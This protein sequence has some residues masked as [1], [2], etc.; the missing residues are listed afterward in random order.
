ME[1]PHPL[2]AL[3]QLQLGSDS[4]AVLHLPYV[5]EALTP[6][7][8]LPSPHTEKWTARVNSLL[9]SKD[10]G[11]RWSGLCLALQTAAFSRPLMMECAQNWI[12]IALPMLSKNEPPPTMKA[13]IRLLR[14]VSPVRSMFQN[15]NGSCEELELKLL[16]I[17][18]LAHLIPL[19]P[20]L[21][22]ALQN[23]LNTLALR[24]LNGSA[25]KPTPGPLLEVASR[26]YS[27][28]PTTG[29][30]VGASNI[31]RKSIDDTLVFAWTALTSIRTTY[32]STGC[33]STSVT[34]PGSLGVDPMVSIPLNTDRLRA[35][36]H[37][38]CDL[39]RTTTSRPISVPVGSLV[40]LF[41]ALLRCTP[42]EKVDGHIDSSVRALEKSVIP[43]IWELACGVLNALAESAQ[44]HL[45][46]HLPQL[47]SHV[48]YH[49]EQNLTPSQRLPFLKVT[50]SLFA[51]CH[52]MHD[53]VLSSRLLRAILPSLT[54]VL[55]TKSEVQSNTEQSTKGKSKGKKRA[56]G[57]E[58]DEVFKVTREIICS[59]VDDGAV[60]LA[61]LDAIHLVMQ[62]AQISPAVHS[63]AGRMLLSIYIALPQIPPALLSPDLSLHGALYVK[64][65][66]I[67][68]DL[69]IGTTST[70]S[71]SLGLII[72][73]ME[74]GDSEPRDANVQRT[75]DLLLHPRV[76]PLVRALPH[77]E[78][79]SLF[80]EEEGKEEM[81]ARRR[82]GIGAEG[83]VSTPLSAEMVDTATPS[84]ATPAGELSREPLPEYSRSQSVQM[85]TDTSIIHREQALPKIAANLPVVASYAGFTEASA[86]QPS[87]NLTN[88]S[89]TSLGTPARSP[90]WVPASAAPS[91]SAAAIP[92]TPIATAAPDFAPMDQDEDDEP[93]PTID[94]D[95]DSD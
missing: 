38:L 90:P 77:V 80:R 39:L 72:S 78:M 29:G 58:G 62:S 36:T 82:L 9:N 63:L 52:T 75:I 47:I 14:H 16:A 26:L 89:T 57:Y 3:L 43:T 54:V 12:G 22:R 87:Q 73:S 71:K 66:N 41:L 84:S 81:E 94:M 59:T 85:P 32:P 19:Y 70:M 49:L 46:P 40:R 51:N 27:V 56:R 18:T 92:V 31:W 1:D 65:R 33:M 79:L 91:I 76:P 48:T 10:S 88:H 21:H 60:L 15:F 86:V 34:Q 37:V 45:T 44:S 23:S 74:D 67:C 83:G 7:Y 8:F 11:A 5:L 13:A 6:E 30:K 42:V 50:A 17:S 20:T 25:P 64:V 55:S 68:T 53:V 95:S 69:A 4:Y 61:A 93:M 28:L 2:K 35:A 24:Y